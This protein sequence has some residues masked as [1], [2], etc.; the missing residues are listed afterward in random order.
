MLF[1]HFSDEFKAKYKVDARTEQ[2]AA[3][4]LKMQVERLKKTL[5]ANPP[6]LETPI[7]VECMMQVRCPVP[8]SLCSKSR[9]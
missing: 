8:H 6:E 2:K 4:R 3:L 5:S 1:Q 7:N 9:P